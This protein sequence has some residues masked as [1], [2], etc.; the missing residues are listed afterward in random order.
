MRSDA[1]QS[2]ARA[3]S[4]LRGSLGVM[5]IGLCPLLLN[6]SSSV[7]Q[8]PSSEALRH[9]NLGVALMD[10]GVEDPEYFREAV[11]EF[12]AALNASSH[13]LNARINLGMAYYYS[14]E[15]D[16]AVA[17]L[18]GAAKDEPGDLHVNFMLGLVKEGDANFK[19]AGPHFL[20]V[21]LQDP[22]DPSAWY[23]LGLCYSKEGRY[24]E[25]VEPFQRA[26]AIAPYQRAYRYNLFMA[27]NRAGRT[28]EA[29]NELDNFKML[30]VSSIRV[31]DAP[32]N[33]REYL[34]QGKYAEAIAD[35]TS[36]SPAAHGSPRYVDV[37][38][39]VG[40]SF[41][42]EGA[43]DDPGVR[44]VLQGEMTPRS[45]FADEGNRRKLIAAISSGSAFC[46][47]NNDGRLDAFL[48]T[49]GGGP[50]LFEQ[51]A[52]GTFENVT[53]EV[54]LGVGPPMGMACA[55]GDYDNDGWVD[56]L[57]TGY[58]GVRL[59]HNRKGSFEDVT[60]QT[61]IAKSISP[62]T[63]CMGTSFADVDH[64]GDLDIYVACLIDLLKV[65]GKSEVTFPDDFA[66]QPNLLFR[67]NRDG[68]F[69]EIARQAKADGGSVA[70]CDVWFSDVNDDRAVDFVLFDLAGHTRTFLNNKD[71]AFSESELL[72]SDPPVRSPTGESHAFGDF[73]RDGAI[74][75]LIVK[76]GAAAVLNRNQA[77]PVNWLTVRLNGYAAP[78]QVKSNK[79]GIG[80]KIEVRS[81]GWWEHKELR[82]GN[83]ARGSDAAEVYFDLADQQ[84]VDFV[85]ATFPSGVRLTLRDLKANQVIEMSEPLL[86]ANSCPVLFAWNGE[87]FEFISDTISAGILGELVAPNQYWPPDPDEWVRITDGQLK[88]G[89]RN[90]LDL[91]FVNPLEEVTYLDR[92]RLVAID[93][94]ASVEVYPNERMVS[95]PKNRGAIS[96]YAL[97][98]LR[99]IRA[100]TDQHGCN[101]TERLSKADRSYFDHFALM[102]FKGF[103]E[104]WS[105]TLDMGALES[106]RTV[107]L[108]HSWS[109][110]N[111]SASVIAAAQA[112]RSLWGPSLDVL[113]KDGK[114][115]AGIEDMGVSAGLPRTIVVDLSAVI[116]PGE[117]I[118]RIRSN[119]TLYYDQVM[120][121]QKTEQLG[122]DEQKTKGT[123]MRAAEVPLLFAELRWLGYPVRVLPDGKLPE[124]YDYDRIELHADWATHGGLLTRYGDALPLL[125]SS[126]DRFVVMG[127]GEEVALSF[128]ASRLPEL[129]GGYKRTYL[130]Y[131]AGYE[132]SYELYS[133]AS[134]TVD[135]LPYRAMRSYPNRVEIADQNQLRYVFEWNT[136]PSFLR[137]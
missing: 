52:D 119:R 127:N 92:V 46:D 66:R 22:Q 2:F 122:L 19:N 107:L 78:G 86:D 9:N 111:S 37:A 69:T 118:V 51:K 58:G 74:D 80:A 27:L 44:R 12:E 110:W 8:P 41:K 18:E 114:W 29:Q 20:M 130:L 61:G 13:Y 90:S 45:W 77:R 16:Q 31:V 129:P 98:S 120:T 21:T 99:P 75:Q 135:P 115:R 59:Y 106:T 116:K 104:D 49:A 123:L 64:D 70:S 7:K 126:D 23:Q 34:K 26:A 132:K 85:R 55:W 97:S 103:A 33:Q 131:S 108:L 102:P 57:I 25:A 105:L 121:A 35:S 125:I 24:A 3:A 32:K 96:A 11:K 109:Y 40:L 73:D 14:G 133:A 101:V 53:A 48:V 94:P 17:A 63:W 4:T 15:R 47:Y 136:R 38:A 91:R 28:A 65:P 88:Q 100:A 54:G 43:T 87:R 124:V 76:N 112:G 60:K 68:T 95:E 30:E 81:V 5:L 137:R 72:P 128:D 10:A 89:S 42:H 62:T 82:A 36:V 56:L 6:C 79:M 83:G 67:N 117:H 1:A 39:Q 93:H 113:G 71:G 134:Q 50:A 84:S